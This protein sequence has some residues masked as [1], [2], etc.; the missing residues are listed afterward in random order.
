MCCHSIR[1][2]KDKSVYTV[3]S[4]FGFGIHEYFIRP[5]TGCT[6]PSSQLWKAVL[7]AD[8]DRETANDQ[9]ISRLSKSYTDTETLCESKERSYPLRVDP[10]SPISH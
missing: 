8:R 4:S 1:G 2:C 5:G 7:M 9:A 6:A 10:T 3:K